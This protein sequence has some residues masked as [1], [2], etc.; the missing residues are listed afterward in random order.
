MKVKVKSLSRVWLFATLWDCIP[1]GSSVHGI[2]QARILEC[3]AISFSRGP[4]WSRDR[5][6]VS[7]IAGRRFNLWATREAQENEEI[8]IYRLLVQTCFLVILLPLSPVPPYGSITFMVPTS[9]SPSYTYLN[10]NSSSVLESSGPDKKH[11]V[12]CSGTIQEWEKEGT[13]ELA[14]AG[15]WAAR[16]HRGTPGGWCGLISQPQGHKNVLNMDLSTF[17]N[18]LTEA[19]FLYIM[20][21]L[22]KEDG[23]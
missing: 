21:N 6:W 9:P 8:S 10:P 2:L 23:Q 22:M 18:Y 4:S 20:R 19:A 11:R 14:E 7:R 13:P 16:P 17:K 5:T 1:P 3:I 12:Q 15:G